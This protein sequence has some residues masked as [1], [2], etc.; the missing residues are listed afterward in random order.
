MAIIVAFG[1]ASALISSVQAK[2]F[3]CP[4]GDVQC[5]IAAIAEVNASGKAKNRIDLEAGTYTLVDVNNLTDGANGLPSI[6]GDLIIAGAGVDLTILERNSNADSF[7]LGHVAATGTLVL[8][9][10]TIQ[11]FTQTPY[12]LPLY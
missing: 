5:L 2:T 11:G 12:P 10:L 4:A 3:H 8:D 9:G 1:L 6:L 7:R